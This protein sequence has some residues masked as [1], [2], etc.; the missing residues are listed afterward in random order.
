MVVNRIER[1]VIR[2]GHVNHGA[3]RRLCVAARKVANATLYQM[4]QA[5][6]AEA[7]ISAS[8]A[9]KIL[10]REHK[11]IYSLLPSAGSQRITQVVGDSWKSWIKA[12]ADYA[13]HP[14]KYKAR[15]RLPGYTQGARTYV[16]NRNGYKIVGGMIHLSGAKAF[17]FQPVKTT[18]CQHQ[19]FNA[20]AS[21]AVVTDLRIVPLGTSFCIEIGYTKE[22]KNTPLLDMNRVFSLDIGIDNL[23]AIT[24][25]QP[26]YRPVL[27]KGKVIK[28]IN[29]KYN[30]DKEALAKKGKKRHIRSKVGKRHAR[31]HDY[32]HKVS[33]WIVSECVRT[34]TGKL[35]IGKNPGWKQAVNIGRVNN[36]KFTAIPHAKLIDMIQYKAEAQGIT[37]VLMN[38]AYTSKASALDLDPIP[39]YDEA[40]QQKPTFSGR[41]VKRGLYRTASRQRIN[42]DVNG[43]ANIL[44]K[45]IGNEWISDH[46][47]AGKGVVD[48][49]IA[50]THID[51]RLSL[52]ACHRASETTSNG[53]A[54]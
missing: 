26:D 48:T 12:K 42:A 22:I 3:C 19:A 45:E 39:D 16:V 20:K 52:E 28:S 47:R 13:R 17:G 46:L 14:E 4:R 8:Q 15:P 2:P 7:P 6:F 41:R 38:E 1:I 49:P 35:V 31:I 40:R 43:S 29:A 21:E 10:K 33:H 11:D 37:V 50:I 32:F 23:V 54:A 25:N 44:R 5:L 18:V 30:K 36:Q 9:D 34:R 24:S 51:A 27:I 53:A